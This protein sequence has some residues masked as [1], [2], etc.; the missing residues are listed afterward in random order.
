M[1][2]Y[3]GQVGPTVH[4]RST[5]NVVHYRAV[6]SAI[7]HH[8]GFFEDERSVAQG[9]YRVRHARG[10]RAVGF[11]GLVD[12]LEVTEFVEPDSVEGTIHGY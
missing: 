7:R 9:S 6:R 10:V 3:S 8:F 2:R 4:Q 11:T 5:A 12:V 1:R